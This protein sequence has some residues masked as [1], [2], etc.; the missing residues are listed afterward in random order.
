MPSSPLYREGHNRSATCTIHDYSSTGDGS[1]LF[2]CQEVSYTNGNANVISDLVTRNIVQTDNVSSNYAN[3]ISNTLGNDSVYTYELNEGAFGS[4]MRIVGN[5]GAVYRKSRQAADIIK[6]DIVAA[7]SGFN[8]DRNT[9]NFN[10]VEGLDSIPSAIFDSLTSID[11]DVADG[12]DE[13]LSSN[14]GNLFMSMANDVANEM[15]SYSKKLSKINASTQLRK[16]ELA[17]KNKIEKQK[18]RLELIMTMPESPSKERIQSAITQ[19]DLTLLLS[20]PSN[21]NKDKKSLYNRDE[22]EL[23]VSEVLPE[24]IEIERQC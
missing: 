22:Y 16:A 18:K 15:R 1:S 3:N 4:R 7:R 19:G 17:A 9:S 8:D 10:P 23:K 6:N 20:N 21:E 5:S 11:D 24:L 12:D 2:N 13:P 14:G